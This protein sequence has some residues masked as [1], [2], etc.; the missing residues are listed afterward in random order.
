MKM[1]TRIFDWILTI[2]ALLPLS[3]LAARKDAPF[4]TS[5][6]IYGTDYLRRE[7]RFVGLV[8][9]A[10][11]DEVD[12]EIMFIVAKDDH[13]EVFIAVRTGRAPAWT[14]D[15]L[16]DCW[17]SV[18]ARCL[19][20]AKGEFRTFANRELSVRSTND[21]S[22]VSRPVSDPFDIP[23][24]E[25]PVDLPP[26]KLHSIG[27]RRMSGRVVAVKGSDN[28]L[29]ET[30][31]GTIS[32]IEL[33][34]QPPPAPGA[35][36]EVAGN[37]ETD[38]HHI[39][40][41]RAIWRT[42][43]PIP[44]VA[45]APTN[46]SARVLLQDESSLSAVKRHFHGRKVCI[47]GKVRSLPVPG[48]SERTFYVE[49]DGV[50]FPACASP[51]AGS[52]LDLKI[53]CI[54]RISGVCWFDIE[55]W[56]PN[57][58]FP[59]FKGFTLV[60][61]RSDDIEIVAWPPW[62]TPLR[63]LCLAVA[64]LAG[65]LASLAWNIS[66]RRIAERRGRQYIREQVA[67]IKA[68]L[69]TEERSRL[70][71]ELHDSISQVLTGVALKIKAAQSIAR[72]DLERALCS[73]SHAETALRSSRGELRNCLWDLRNSILDVQDFEEAL[74][75]TL[76]PHTGDAEITVRFLVPRRKLTDNTA[77]AIL[78]IVRELATNAIR[79]GS[80]TCIVVE[81]RL[82]ESV[83]TFSVADNGCGFCPDKR[84]GA[85]EGHYGLQGI[86]ERLERMNGSLSIE[87]DP[88]RGTKITCS[89]PRNNG[90]VHYE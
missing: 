60:V 35:S 17:I 58:V 82:E 5:E 14:P 77:H 54:A 87:S 33:R 57:A 3:C 23:T 59:Q 11:R 51:S 80:A 71:V 29:M 37:V 38:L 89:I 40:L 67:R 52:L 53:D 21:I 72:T 64:L 1:R 85:S 25:M 65:L 2:A 69:K 83:I 66:L 42:T 61:Q 7:V 4:V 84:V 73:L 62:W 55:N 12:P 90:A 50:T 8:K 44:F 74:R 81:G 34:D 30:T 26:W 48:R 49:S 22:I 78:Q 39:N 45:Q 6:D 27:R 10:F 24:L 41:T 15:D 46:I 20:T 76:R 56:R 75:M 68:E 13:G 43:D 31:S 9:D 70:A 19:S 32:R 18:S 36:V 63:L 86:Q 28:L 79:H 47:T 16:I 88:G